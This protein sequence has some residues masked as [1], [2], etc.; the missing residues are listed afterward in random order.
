MFERLCQV[1]EVTQ[2]TKEIAIASKI[3]AIVATLT[4]R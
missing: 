3:A 2:E 4:I 1:Q